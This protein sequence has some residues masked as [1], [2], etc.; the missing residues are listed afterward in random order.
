[1][2]L[3]VFEFRQCQNPTCGLRYPVQRDNTAGQRCP[4]CLGKTM[5]VGVIHAG[6]ETPTARP[7][8]ASQPD[9][10]VLIDNVRSGL[11]V[12]SIFRSADGYGIAHLYLCGITPKPQTAEVAKTALG[13]EQAMR[14]SA[15]RNA[16]GLVR[17]LKGA[18]YCIWALERTHDS[19]NIEAA[20]AGAP[21]E[22]RRVLVVGNEQ[23]GIDPGIL[24]LADKVVHLEMR[25]RKQSFNVAVAF[26]IAA[27]IMKR[28]RES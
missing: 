8:T 3:V 14:W 27:H 17:S 12:G 1:M 7:G 4:I 26:A 23:A 25:G 5:I 24:E 18:G 13:S 22:Q 10:C 15:H 21:P 6:M 9:L 20:L 19:K 2:H 28:G 16:V 11:N